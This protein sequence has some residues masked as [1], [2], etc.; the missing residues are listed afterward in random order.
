MVKLFWYSL[1]NVFIFVRTTMNIS[2]KETIVISLRNNLLY[3][4]FG[5]RKKAVK[6]LCLG[7]LINH[8]QQ[9]GMDN[10]L[11]KTGHLTL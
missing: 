8:R 10:N 5:L 7:F 4:L 1:T 3:N 6:Q 11:N 2:A 9:F